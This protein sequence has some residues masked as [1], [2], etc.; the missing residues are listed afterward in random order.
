MINM[1]K[2]DFLKLIIRVTANCNEDWPY[3]RVRRQA[4]KIFEETMPKRV[5]WADRFVLEGYTV[6]MD[7]SVSYDTLRDPARDLDVN[8]LLPRKGMEMYVLQICR[9]FGLDKEQ[10]RQQVKIIMRPFGK[11]QHLASVRL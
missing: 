10:A 6:L 3:A 9:R 7:H 11:K 5:G 1:T 8:F 4:E 2:G